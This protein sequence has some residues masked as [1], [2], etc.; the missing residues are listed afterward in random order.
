[1]NG[2]NMGLIWV[3]L[4]PLL[5]P[6]ASPA[7]DAELR[8]VVV[9]IT[10]E[11]GEPVEGVHPEEL[12][13]IENGVTRE[14]AKVDPEQEPL[15]VALLADNSENV[16]SFFRLD[17]VDGL[18]TF[19]KELPQGSHFSVWT[20][21]D[22]PNKIVDFTDDVGAASAA[23]KRAFP[24]GGNT[25]LDAIVEASRD[26][27]KRE[28]ERTAVVV[29]TS[30]GVDFSNRDQHRTVDEAL[31]NA[32]IFAAVQ[33]EEGEVLFETRNK[34]EYALG[35]LTSKTGG[36]YDRTL[37]AMGVR[38]GLHKVVAD[39]KGRYRLQYATLTGI[40]SRKVDVKIA[41][42]DTQVRVVRQE[43]PK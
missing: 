43:E 14:V 18:V 7:P 28:G 19:L 1:M 40:K 39:L 37:S 9:S 30:L 29:V 21:G 16:G 31:G 6:Q 8:T 13:L 2:V 15:A 35:M 33:F 24:R 34:Y 20:T 3:V 11:K 10:K 42:P 26:L 17:I 32:K 36:V 4:W 5:T 22:R 25:L 41:R 12:A 27:K 38:V 23:L